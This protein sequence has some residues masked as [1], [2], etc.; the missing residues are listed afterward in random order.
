MSQLGVAHWVASLPLI[1][2]GSPLHLARHWHGGRH[3][4]GRSDFTGRRSWCGCGCCCRRYVDCVCE[5]AC[6][7]RIRCS[8]AKGPRPSRPG[9]PSGEGG[10]WGAAWRTCRGGWCSR[11][12]AAR[13]RTRALGLGITGALGAS[14]RDRGWLCCWVWCVGQEVG[15]RD[16][17]ASSKD[18]ERL[19][20]GGLGR[21]Q[22]VAV[23]S[24]PR[25][26]VP[27]APTSRATG[28]G[29]PP[30]R[31]SEGRAS[32][33]ACLQETGRPRHRDG[34]PRAEHCEPGPGRK[35]TQPAR[36]DL[37]DRPP[38]VG[39]QDSGGQESFQFTER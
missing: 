35:A 2:R 31:G 11:N 16:G 26:P 21:R 3:G 19:V 8:C 23:L 13:N 14:P 15:H 6:R 32:G 18:A 30:A 37:H 25:R 20:D 7:S 39:R 5:G 10:G 17:P 33:V 22:V 36:V 27:L 9:A 12:R 34:R 1:D 38:G 4:S 29:R 24:H 28:V